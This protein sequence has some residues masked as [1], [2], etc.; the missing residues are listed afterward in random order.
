MVQEVS[1]LHLFSLKDRP[2]S[3]IKTVILFVLFRFYVCRSIEMMVY[4]L[5]MLHWNYSF[6]GGVKHHNHKIV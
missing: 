1:I 3:Q 6:E 4:K 2:K 5:S